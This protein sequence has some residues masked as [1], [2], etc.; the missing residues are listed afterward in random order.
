MLEDLELLVE[1]PLSQVAVSI[2]TLVAAQW[3]AITRLVRGAE[4]GAE[5]HLE[6][7]AGDRGEQ[8]PH[9]GYLTR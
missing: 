7:R 4:R 1:G 3:R 5:W 6:R 8:Q 9:R 2:D